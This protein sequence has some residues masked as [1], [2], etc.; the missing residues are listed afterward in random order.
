M[1][2]HD[3]RIE[4]L[5][6]SFDNLRTES[7]EGAAMAIALGG[8]RIPDNRDLALGVRLGHYRSADAIAA[9]GAFRLPETTRAVVR[10]G[11]AY[12][13]EQSRTRMSASIV[14]RW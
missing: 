13:F 3:R 7:H 11:V 4:S 1:D 9:A 8:M 10:V 12:G 2:R 14:W 6:L 5:Q